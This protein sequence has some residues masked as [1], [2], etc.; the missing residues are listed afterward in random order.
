M[1]T[2]R[3]VYTIL[4]S[5]CYIFPLAGQDTLFFENFDSSPGSKP[6]GWTTELESGDSKWQ[7]VNGGGTKRPDIPGS[8]RPPSAYSG[9][10]NALYFFESLEGEEVILVT[11][12]VNLEFALRP[13]LRFMHVQREGNLGFG[14]AHDELR[15]YFKTHFDSTWKEINKIAEFTDEVYDWT[16]QTVL[17]PEEAFVEECYFAFKA[18]TNYGWGVGIDDVNVIETDIQPRQVE[19]LAIFQEETGILPTGS[20]NNPMLRINVSV[21]GNSGAIALNSLD[22]NSLNTDDTDI[23]AKGVKL[24]YNYSNRNFFAATLLDSTSFVS[25]EALFSSLDLNLPSGHTSL[26]IAYDIKSDAIHNNLADV[27]I[28]AGNMDIGGNTYPVSDASPAGNRVIQEAVFFDDFASDKSWILTGDFERDQPRGLGGQNLGNP[29]PLFA[30]GDTMILGNDLTGLG[31]NPGDYEASVSRYDNL[32]TSPVI[33]LFYYNDVSMNFLRWLNVA[34]NDTASIDMSIDGGNSWNEIWSNDN[35]VFS[36]GEWNPYAQNL[37]EAYRQSQVQIR[38]NLGPTTPTDQ[39]SGWNIENFAI[40]GN[41]VEY[42]VSPLTLLGPGAGCGLSAAETVSIRVE[43]LGPGATPDLIPV[44]YSFDGGSSFTNDV[45]SGSIAFEGYMDF[46]FSEKIDLSTPGVYDVVIE[47]TLDVDEE[48]GNNRLDTVFYVDPTYPLPYYQDFENGNDFWRVE[49]SN[50]TFEHGSPM[51]SI[52]HTAASGTKAWVTNLDGTYSDNEDSYLLGPCFDFTDIDYPVFECNLYINTEDNKDGVNLEYS[53]DNGQSW[54]RLGNMG[55]GA[56]FDWNWYNSDVISSLSGG[57]GWTDGLDDWFTARIMLD[58]TIF[59]DMPGVKFRF[60]FSSDAAGRLEGIG[61]DDIRIYGTPRDLGVISIENPVNGCAQDI[62]DYVAVTV[63]NFG[64]DTLMAGDTI[65]LGYDFDAQATVI[66]TFVLSS[67]L[68]SGEE[69]PYVFTKPLVVTSEGWMD[70]EAFTLLTDDVDFYNET[71]TND[72]TSKAVEIVQTPFVFLPQEI[73]TVRPDTVVLD[74]GTGDPT[75]TYLWQDAS[76]DSVFNVSAMAD[77]MYHVTASNAYCSYSDTTYVYRLIADVGVTGILEPASSSCELGASVRPSIRIMNFGT[78]TMD[79]GDEIPVRYQIDAGAIVEEMA[80]VPGPFLP[81]SSF[82]YTFSTSSDMSVAKTYIISAF[83]ELAFDDTITNDQM[84]MNVE[85]FGYTPIDLGADTAI[86]AFDYT[87]DAGAGYDSY[88]W[89]DS[90][91]QQTLLVDTTGQYWVTVK[92]G[93][94]CEN[95]DT[96]QVTFIIP[97]IG[98]E[99]LSNPTDACGFSATEHVEFYIMN[100]GTDTLYS[101][102][103]VFVSYQFEGG[104]LMYDTLYVDRTVGP[105]DSILF[106]SDSTVDVSGIGSYDFS[107]G[108]SFSEDMLPG[109]DSLDQSIEIYGSPSVDLGTDQVVN[110]R[111]HSLDAGAGF[112]AYVWQDGSAD[113]LFLVEFE[114]QTLDSSYWVNVV[115]IH[116]CEAADTVKISFDLWDVGVTSMASP[117]TACSLTDR[118]EL[119]LFVTNFGTH[120]IVDEQVNIVYSV[121]GGNLRT[122]QYT[123]SQVLNPGDSIEYLLGSSFD[124]SGVGNHSVNAYTMYGKDNDPFNDTLDVTVTHLG[125]PQPELGGENDSLRTSLPL[126]LDGGAGYIAY[127]WNGFAGDQTYE[128]TDYGWYVLEVMN[129]EGCTGGD[130][131][132]LMDPTGIEDFRLEGELK[133]YPIPSSQVLHVDYRGQDVDKLILEIFDPSGRKIHI[134]EFT[135][136]ADIKESIDVTGIATGVYYLRLRTDQKHLLRKIVID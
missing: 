81:D 112:A 47:T 98:I 50:P 136:A 104:A 27:M 39:L 5:I 63:K 108:I 115:D 2:N 133:V 72:T 21:K 51:G 99:R 124:F 26:W 22:V 64:L 114:N 77:G 59:R 55:D 101:S 97:D 34:N 85:V 12:P 20:R 45:I 23:S 70:I 111:T 40:T 28:Q 109:N 100:V 76:T 119:R 58:T 132:Y 1:K 123:I 19:E 91:T 87:V 49:G 89:L 90:S 88:M 10:V 75:D 74:A 30:S 116:G 16:E 56:A 128:A 92:Q 96:V 15:I 53:L 6:D 61:I 73:S 37:T 122:A 130:S 95:T 84:Q 127:E 3:L 60:H 83:T 29:D 86:R 79:V 134:Q 103:S 32:A 43:N 78:D 102:D 24:Y 118:E 46:D 18:K 54:V 107:V 42:D 126:T 14:A 17:L 31:A 135:N 41:Y 131:V 35:N 13:E 69:R 68:L 125:V 65:M 80:D 66:D 25:G 62:G 71:S 52:I 7:F 11:P 36:D 8:G 48:V 9:T 94:M 82:V 33:D 67:E 110:S 93:S 113:Q 117:G 106:S 120:P 105:G 44:R 57:H 129:S 121:D 38:F 4:I